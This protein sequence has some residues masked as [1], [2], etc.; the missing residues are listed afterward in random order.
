MLACAAMGTSAALHAQ[1]RGP[2]VSELRRSAK[3][4]EALPLVLD[5]ATRASKIAEMEAWLGRLV[6]R[7]RGEAVVANISI[8]EKIESTAVCSR[9]GDGSGV[10]CFI[11][12]SKPERVALPEGFRSGTTIIE[13]N[14]GILPVLYFG[15]NPDTLEIQLMIIDNRQVGGR[16]G[17]LAGNTVDFSDNWKV[18][19]KV[20]WGECWME[21]RITAEP[22]GEIFM[23]FSQN[24]WLYGHRTPALTG[25]K[26]SHT[27]E[28][29]LHLHRELPVD[30]DGPRSPP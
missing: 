24:H 16:S 22:T 14:M 30:A 7:F 1:A 9:F 11:G 18:C 2:S 4:V 27:F 19:H 3:Q 5:E 12:E 25:G 10:R 8:I 17:A 15:I 6:G 29:E 21:A 23:K 13:T 20:T 28:I 26:S